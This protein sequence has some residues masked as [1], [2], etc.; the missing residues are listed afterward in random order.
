MPQSRSGG[1]TA[2]NLLFQLPTWKRD[3]YKCLIASRSPKKAGNR[4]RNREV[5][6][7]HSDREGPKADPV[8]GELLAQFPVVG[9]IYI[10]PFAVELAKIGDGDADEKNQQKIGKYGNAA[11][12]KSMRC[13]HYQHEGMDKKSVSDL[14][15][16]SL[17][18][19]GSSIALVRN[20]MRLSCLGHFSL[21]SL[22]QQILFS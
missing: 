3:Q 21:L 4:F 5:D 9:S 11:G 2:L 16:H 6:K 12:F 20:K 18:K 22:S 14:A 1:A 7:R 13:D 10:L 17:C 19:T 8:V 15:A